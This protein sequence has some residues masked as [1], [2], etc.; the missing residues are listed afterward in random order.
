M[1]IL[2]MF[3]GLWGNSAWAADK[4]VS[5]APSDL[6]T[7]DVVVIVDQTSSSAMSNDKGTSAAPI[8]TGVTLND[9]KSE[10]T[11]DVAENLQ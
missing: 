7:G 1:G 6:T 10:I 3:A 9:D 8:A 2:A 4:W 5:T 11:G